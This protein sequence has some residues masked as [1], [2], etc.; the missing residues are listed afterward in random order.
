MLGQFDWNADGIC[1]KI[2]LPLP[3]AGIVKIKQSTSSALTN[4]NPL[5]SALISMTMKEANCSGKSAIE[6]SDLFYDIIEA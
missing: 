3:F 1:W 5:L 4:R 6:H 2:K